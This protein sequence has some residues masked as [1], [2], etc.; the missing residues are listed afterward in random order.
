MIAYALLAEHAECGEPTPCE[1]A[2]LCNTLHS[3]RREWRFEK[4]SSKLGTIHGHM[5]RITRD[6]TKYPAKFANGW[7]LTGD[8]RIMVVDSDKLEPLWGDAEHAAYKLGGIEAVK[9]LQKG[10]AAEKRAADRAAARAAKK[11]KA[12]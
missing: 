4:F 1:Y 12:A 3:K 7:G 5:S 2:H 10:I 9:R 8:L 11:A 6:I